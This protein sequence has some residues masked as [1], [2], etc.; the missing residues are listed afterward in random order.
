MRSFIALAAIAAAT[1]ATPQPPAVSAAPA[2]K[3]AKAVTFR[4]VQRGSY[5]AGASARPGT[6]RGARA[7][8]ARDEGSYRALWQQYAGGGEPPAVDFSRETSV[9]LSLGQR[10]T[11]GYSITPNSVAVEGTTIVVD[12]TIS[13]PSP[14][15]VV[16][17]AF[18]SPFAVIAVSITSAS[19]LR[20]MDGG[21]EVMLGESPQAQER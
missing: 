17:M 16:T 15:S 7:A 13:T 9:F 1:C 18:S 5:G 21:H 8:M 11:G 19:S 4:L 12:A 14:G 20:W 3:E 10:P 2:A 6:S